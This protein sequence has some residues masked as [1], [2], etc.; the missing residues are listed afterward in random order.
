MMPSPSLASDKFNSLHIC[1]LLRSA[2]TSSIQID[3]VVG[4]TDGNPKI[5]VRDQWGT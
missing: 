1:L 3:I 2:F 5:H 4:Q